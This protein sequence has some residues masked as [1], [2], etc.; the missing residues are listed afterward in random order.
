MKTRVQCGVTAGLAIVGASVVAAMPVAQQA[1]EVLKSSDAKVALTAASDNPIDAAVR[2]AQGFGQSGERLAGSLATSPLGLLPILQ[3][4]AAGSNDA[5]QNQDLFD[6]LVPYLDGGQYAFDPIIFALDDVLPAPLGQDPST[7]PTDMGGSEIDLFRANVLL[8]ARD[9]VD[10]AVAD[11]LGVG[12]RADVD[13]E[14]LIYDAARV[15]AGLGVSAMRA[16]T[17]AVTAP[18]GLVAVAQGLQHSFQTGDN[19]ALYSAL[20]AYIDGPNYVTDPIVFAADDVL[21]SPVGSDPA[22]D[23]R[24][25]GGSQISNFRADVL[26][27]ARDNVRKA[28]AGILDVDTV[29]NF[30][31]SSRGANEAVAGAST[32]SATGSNTS[33]AAGNAAASKKPIT[34]AVKAFNKELKAGAERID[35]TV[36]KLT[37]QDDKEKKT[38]DNG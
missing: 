33:S 30:S 9:D 1:P 24:E 35:H 5:G 36:K 15:G 8:A 14:S 25:M 19:T 23:P 12:E 20:E 11:A 22:T 18:L 13:N 27:G 17:T 7:V 34:T 2:L 28:V 10:E 31:A 29:N 37:G 21:P 6:A 32:P 26:L 4:V 3:A 16:A 38:A